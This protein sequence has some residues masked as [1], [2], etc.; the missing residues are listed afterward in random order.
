MGIKVNGKVIVEKYRDEI[1][2]VIKGGISKGLRVPSIK[3]ILVGD[4]GGSTSYVKSQNN[5]C[6]KLG[7]SYT[8]IHL[9]KDVDQKDIVD[10]IEKLNEDNTVDGVIIQLPL[11]KKFNEKEI[12]S[13]IS[14][15][16]DIDGLSDVN[17]GRFYKG[18][19]SF[20]PCTALGV[21]E[22]IK[23][24][25]C[26]IKGKHA[27]VIGRSNIVGKPGAQLLLNEDATV[28]ICHSKTTN[29]KEVCKT[30]DI[31]VAAIGKPGFVTSDFI[32]EG[33]VVIDVGTTMVNNKVTGDV[34][35]DDVINHAS[36]VTPVPGGTGLM[37]TTMLIK[38]ACMAW[39]DNV[40]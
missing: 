18:E 4:D 20:I 5:L 40:Y 38:N 9:D 2:S 22:M 7:I 23:S 19:K 1:K 37:T 3:T 30:A 14:Y 8:C 6:N 33:A 25:G 17:M 12:T 15:K 16:K 39:R 29:L 11:P 28:T 35:F 21:I 26:V 36:Y 13:K 24:T 31:I 32:K 34:S 27:V 10:I